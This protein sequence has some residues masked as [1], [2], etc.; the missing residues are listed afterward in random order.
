MAASGA[1]LQIAWGH[2]YFQP[3]VL[4]E[5]V[6]DELVSS[7]TVHETAEDYHRMLVLIDHRCVFVAG[8]GQ[9]ASGLNYFPTESIQVQ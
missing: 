8:Y 1:W 2:V 9:I 7:Q 6:L 3:T 5:K 4:L